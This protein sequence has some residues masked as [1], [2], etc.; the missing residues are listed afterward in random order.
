MTKG[1][2]NT[3]IVV[4][5]I[6]NCHDAIFKASLDPDELERVLTLG[7]EIQ[8]KESWSC[9]SCLYGRNHDIDFSVSTL[10]T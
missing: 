6:Q 8:L 10:P 4:L 3:L 2:V 1:N 7:S 9:P 5:T